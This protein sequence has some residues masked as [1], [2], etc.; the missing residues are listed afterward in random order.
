M[1]IKDIATILSSIATLIS[2]IAASIQ[3]IQAVK[4][5]KLQVVVRNALFWI[6]SIF[7]RYGFEEGTTGWVRQVYETDQGVTAVEQSADEAKFCHSLEMTVDLEGGHTNKSRGEAYVEINPQ[8]L[9]NKPITVWVYVPREALGDPEKPNGIQV[10]V[11][12]KDWRGEYG[13][14]W[15][16][17]PAIVDSWQQVTLTPSRSAPPDGYM[18]PGFDPTQ[19]GAVGVK[20]AI[21]E[22]STAK[23]RGPIYVDAVDWP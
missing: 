10:F 2:A 16:I 11:K 12:D 4:K 14:W 20:I 19:I 17:T 21:G 1:E 8:N 9:E 22:G 3:A 18:E 5:R 6:A 7:S 15:N 23:Y 13:I